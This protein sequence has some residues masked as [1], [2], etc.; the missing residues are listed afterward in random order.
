[1]HRYPFTNSLWRQHDETFPYPK[2]E[3]SVSCDVVVIGAGIAGLVTAYELQQRG[4]QVVLLEAAEI[5]RGTTGHTTAKCSVQHGTVY[6]K[7]IRTFNLET[8]RLY[9]ELNQEALQ[10]LRGQV[11]D[12]FDIDY[13][14]KDS[15]LYSI[16]GSSQLVAER[17]A[18]EQLE[19]LGGDATKEV[20]AALPL[21]VKQALVIRDQ[22]Q[23]H[24]VKYLNELA[25]RFVEAGGQVYEKTR[26][27]EISG[28]P[29]PIVT[30]S[31]GRRVQGNQ[32]VVATHYPFNDIRGL[33][34]SKFEVE[35]SYIVACETEQSVPEGMYLSVDTPSRSFR[36]FQE[37]DKTYM[38]VGGEGHLS[39]HVTE[40]RSRYDRLDR[41]AHDTFD[42]KKAS[43]RWSSQDLI[44]LD[45]LPY[46][47]QMFSREPDLF[48]ATGFAK[49]GM[50]NGIASGLLL[51]DLLTGQDNRF[52][53]LLNPLRS[54]FKPTDVGQFLKTNLDTATQFVK[55]SLEKSGTLD[56]LQLDEGG[57]VQVDGKKVGAYRDLDN[58]CHLV[59]TRC[60]HMGCTVNWNDAE[61]SWDCPCHGSRFDTKGNVLEGPATKPLSYERKTDVPKA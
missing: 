8:A 35:R 27:T 6:S 36:T 30:T 46:V 60:T 18:Y 58:E 2:L 56:D 49:W 43:F 13:E 40:T 57:I 10:Y 28:G 21:Q 1:M 50:T 14:A 3:S 5:G 15:Y 52:R 55:G 24:P 20:N 29:R 23:I 7:L 44:T 4:K 22:A 11:T 9:Y 33:Y 41:F 54:K 34:F 31:T 26:A 61:R 17:E 47:G 39:G 25:R 42:T 12:G 38:L 19:L 59:S 16:D 53:E 32:V 48:V 51:A 45:H 37:G